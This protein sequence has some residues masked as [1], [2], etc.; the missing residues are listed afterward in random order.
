MSVTCS[1]IDEG[2]LT[3]GA[4]RARDHVDA[5]DRNVCEFRTDSPRDAAIGGHILIHG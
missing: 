4:A 5:A 1:D 2:A 3:V